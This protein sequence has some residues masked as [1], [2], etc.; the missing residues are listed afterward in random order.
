MEKTYKKVGK[1][2]VE[3]EPSRFEDIDFF[4]FSFLVESC[5]GRRPIARS[6][7]F[8]KVIDKY[9]YVLTQ[10]ERDRLFEWLNRNVGFQQELKD[11]EE[12]CLLFNARFDKDNQYLVSYFFDGENN[13]KETFLYDNEYRIS[14]N[15][16]IDKKYITQI[17]K[18]NG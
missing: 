5:Y 3:I 1:R 7:F 14:K 6:V 9:Y 16:Y 15:T 18:L 8:E 11:K 10:N 13:K 17:E 2:Y 4:E 12:S